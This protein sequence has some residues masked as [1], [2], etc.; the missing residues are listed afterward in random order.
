MIK[1]EVTNWNNKE[2]PLK[3]IHEMFPDHDAN[4]WPSI[5]SSIRFDPNLDRFSDPVSKGFDGV[6]SV[7]KTRMI[8][9]SPDLSLA[10]GSREIY[11]KLK[12]IEDKLELVSIVFIKW[13]QIISAIP[14]LIQDSLET[15]LNSIRRIVKRKEPT[16]ETKRILCL[17]CRTRFSSM[18]PICGG[19]CTDGAPIL[20]PDRNAECE[21][22]I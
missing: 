6:P 11:G 1:N 22:F 9:D 3:A 5:G 18:Y 14:A 21:L 7:Y 15:V 8:G 19:T 20:N 17:I 13:D 4:G 10:G 2:P 16:P 12:T